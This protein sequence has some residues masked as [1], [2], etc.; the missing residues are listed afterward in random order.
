MCYEGRPQTSRAGDDSV[1]YFFRKHLHMRLYRL[2]LLGALSYIDC[3]ASADFAIDI[4][5]LVMRQHFNYVEKLIRICST[6]GAQKLS[7]SNN[8]TELI[9]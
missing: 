5:C 2:Q 7:I 8:N 3:N 1:E 9:P 6:A 4:S